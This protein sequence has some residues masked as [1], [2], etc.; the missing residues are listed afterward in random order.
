MPFQP[1]R[2]WRALRRA[3]AD[4]DDPRAVFELLDGLSFG[5][6]R[7]D[8]ERF[9]VTETGRRVFAEKRDLLDTLRD[10]AYLESL[11]EGSF[12]RAYAE[13]TEREQISADGLVEARGGDWEALLPRPLEESGRD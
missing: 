11:P 6:Y 8:D 12:G 10:R 13:F 2:A 7:R 4:P 1:I 3:Y 9:L 5:A